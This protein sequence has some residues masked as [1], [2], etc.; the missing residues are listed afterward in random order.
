MNQASMQRPWPT[1]KEV[2]AHVFGVPF[3]DEL[4]EFNYYL[5]AALMV[6]DLTQKEYIAMEVALQ[7][8]R[9]LRKKLS[10]RARTYLGEVIGDEV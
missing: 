7:Q 1:N 4:E 6:G 9:P 10:A 2:K 8:L 5:R 3:I